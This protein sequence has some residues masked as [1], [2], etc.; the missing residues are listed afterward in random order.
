MELHPYI[1]FALQRRIEAVTKFLA[2]VSEVHYKEPEDHCVQNPPIFVLLFLLQ[3]GDFVYA[4]HSK[5]I[6]T[7][8]KQPE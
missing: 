6:T 8:S 7:S 5:V 4:R 1:A 3:N 2:D